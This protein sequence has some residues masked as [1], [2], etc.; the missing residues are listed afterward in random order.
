MEF[1]SP[2]RQE[3]ERRCRADGTCALPGQQPG[4]RC[5]VLLLPTAPSRPLPHC[6][7]LEAFFQIPA[8]TLRAIAQRFGVE[9]AGASLC[10]VLRALA[11]HFVP[12]IG[13]DGIAG[14]L[15]KRSISYE[16][17]G[18]EELL[19]LDDVVEA[20]D[21]DEK[22]AASQEL[23]K[24]R[25]HRAER[26]ELTARGKTEGEPGRNKE[27][28]IKAGPLETSHRFA[29]GPVQNISPNRLVNTNTE[30]EARTLEKLPSDGCRIVA[31]VDMVGLMSWPNVSGNDYDNM[32]THW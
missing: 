16:G 28:V 2:A 1:I 26:K 4:Q 23:Q 11:E 20:F 3:V 13:E 25:A 29:C 18:Y 27:G 22:A 10:Q 5:E 32:M 6:V 7:A 21:Q 31:K 14:V 17:E 24:Q 30:S 8:H 15:F 9:T 12:N 19:A